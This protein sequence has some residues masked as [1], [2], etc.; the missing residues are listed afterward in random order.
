M[1]MK[2]SVPSGQGRP[3]LARRFFRWYC[4][5]AFVENLEGDLEEL[6]EERLR[7][8]S[9]RRA[10][11]H[12]VQDVLLLF[13]PSIVCPITSYLTLT[14]PA[15]FRNFLKISLRNLWKYKS[16]ALLNIC[17]LAIGIAAAILLLL[18]VRYEQSYDTFHP[19]HTSI[20]R[21]GESGMANGEEV[22]HWVSRTPTVPTLIEE[23]P[24]VVSGTRFFAPNNI[25]IRYQ[26]KVVNPLVHYADSGF[27]DLF[28]FE[29][30]AGDLQQALSTMN[31]ITL[32]ESVA[33]QLFGWE[34]A[35][36][37]TVEVINSDQQFIVGAVLSDPPAN[38]SLQFKALLPW[39]NRPDWL[40]ID[41]NGDWENQFM[42]G[43]VKIS[44]PTHLTTLTDKLVVF[45]DQHFKSDHLKDIRIKL[46]PLA[47]LRAEETENE[48]VITL[49]S[50]IAA[51]TLVIA[52]IN[53][54]NLA[55]AQSLLRTKEVGI[56][57]A[58]GS[59]RSQ[60]IVQFLTES[61]VTCLLA[62][63]AGML[64]VHLVLPHFNQYFDLALTFHYWQNLSLL[65]TLLA[66]GF[67]TGLLSGIYPAT[68]VARLSPVASL[69]GLGKH[70]LSGRLFQHGLIVVQYTASILLIA[71]TLVIWR[72]IQFMKSQD[73][74]FDKESVVAFSLEYDNYGF[75]SEAQAKSAIKTMIDRLKTESTV[76]SITF[77][78]R[79]PGRY[80]HFESKFYDS[81]SPT[82]D[83][84]NL[85]WTTVGNEYFS[86]LGINIVDGRTF[87]SE[88][89]SDS[90][91]V[92]INETAM[93]A[94][95]WQHVQDKYLINSE[96]NRFPVVGVVKDYHYQSLLNNIQPM[97]HYYYPG[98]EYYYGHIAVRLQ[99][100]RT[101][102]GLAVLEEAY[103]SLN[104]YEPFDYYFLDEE[105]DKMYKS[106]ERLGLTATLFASIAVVL[107]SLGLLALA[108]FA[109]RQR[110]K[111]V[112]IRKVMGASV[113]QVVILLSRNF[114]RLVFI[115]FIV[116]CPLIY[117][118]ANRF[119]QDFAYRIN[120]GADIFLIAGVIAFLIAGVSVSTQAFRAASANPVNSLRDE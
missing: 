36:G 48:S 47:E 49:L 72:Q 95:G 31:Y 43:Y 16:Y 86:T 7:R 62:L 26:D 30:V 23:I 109:A 87:S 21:I 119:L 19:E 64:L 42:T 51:I 2:E 120:L 80:R 68:F 117:Y 78:D 20:Y 37:K 69:K 3:K 13:R 4:H 111:E 50:I 14:Q 57:K 90:S 55:T 106:Q 44:S 10:Q 12:Y 34:E 118:A 94:F 52:S 45:K 100:G 28:A 82:Q 29:T 27:V 67:V 46:L 107:A 5:P 115:A 60:L 99:P 96:G 18:I 84:V 97:V 24:E 54:M 33:D 93:N 70:R 59:L 114:A 71:G 8:M 61:V 63:V 75:Q 116:A 88:L 98:D 66:I 22:V 108:A 101:A 65:G 85:R 40:A 56:R 92:I 83:P 112:G 74:Q 110:R 104:P 81:E 1:R 11:W 9:Q 105:F 35:V 41:Q 38:S 53:F 91:A 76:T 79:M 102:E 25:R 15:M 103:Q 6:H 39:L 113:G 58:I 89:S 73:L 17:G 32:T 77:A